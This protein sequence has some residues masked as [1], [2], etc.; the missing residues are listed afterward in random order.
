MPGPQPQPAALK[1]LRGN[2]GHRPIPKEPKV[3]RTFPAPPKD[4]E[5]EAAAH[6]RGIGKAYAEAG[7]VSTLDADVLRIYVEQFVK[8][9][10]A[11]IALAKEDLV[12]T[13]EK[14]E[15]FRNPLDIIARDTAQTLRMYA[16]ELGLTPASRVGLG[17]TEEEPG[18]ALDSWKAAK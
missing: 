6:W 10:R 18:D 12:L 7:V 13:S 9:R 11:A 17:R 15:R 14:G 3:D 1:V 2:P 5:P 16:R 4:L 8:Y